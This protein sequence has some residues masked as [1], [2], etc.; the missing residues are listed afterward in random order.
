MQAIKKIESVK[1][2]KVSCHFFL[3]C[4]F[5]FVYCV[6][7]YPTS[8]PKKV[9]SLV[10]S[11]LF[12]GYSLVIVLPI[13]YLLRT[14]KAASIDLDDLAADAAGD[15]GRGEGFDV[16]CLEVRH[17]LRGLDNQGDLRLLGT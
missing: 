15:L 2:S 3:L 1:V 6:G 17:T 9:Q 13:T 5:F 12:V 16:L 10:I 8:G 4:T 7:W 14:G 11:W